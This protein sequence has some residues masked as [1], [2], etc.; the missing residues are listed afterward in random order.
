MKNIHYKPMLAVTAALGLATVALTAGASLRSE[1]PIQFAMTGIT[2]NQTARLTVTTVSRF[3]AAGLCRAT[4]AFVDAAG[5]S[6]LNSDGRPIEKRVSLSAGESA[7]LDIMVDRASDGRVNIR[8]VVSEEEGARAGC[9]PQLEIIDT[10]TQ[11][12]LVINAGISVGGWGSNHNES[13][14]P[15]WGTN[16]NETLLVDGR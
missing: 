11:A 7:F 3:G 9:L 8:P 1:T 14:I 5:Q 4:L 10:A 15:G 2:S 16:H 6:L 13:L 12:T